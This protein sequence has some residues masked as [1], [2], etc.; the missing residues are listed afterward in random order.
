M[1][2]I[3]RSNRSRIR[4]FVAVSKGAA[5]PSARI[6]RNTLRLREELS[7][8]PARAMAA[9]EPSFGPPSCKTQARWF[10]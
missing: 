6:A 5:T 3:R 9:V 4:R 8:S 10:G 2:R 1:S 7:A